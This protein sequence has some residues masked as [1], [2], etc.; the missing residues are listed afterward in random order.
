M[1]KKITFYKETPIIRKHITFVI[2]TIKNIDVSDLENFEDEM[3][4]RENKEFDT[5]H[6]I[7]S[8]QESWY[9]VK[10]TSG[11]I[12]DENHA[13]LEPVPFETST[14]PKFRNINFTENKK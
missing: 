12:Y 11:E 9:K 8:T 5:V 7:S 3:I 4:I 2:Y 13:H 1:K 10:K 6:V 14:K